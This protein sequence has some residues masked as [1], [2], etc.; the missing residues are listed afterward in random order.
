LGYVNYVLNVVTPESFNFDFESL[1]VVNFIILVSIIPIIIVVFRNKI[2]TLI[3]SVI[4]GLVFIALFG[5]NYI[6]WLGVGIIIILFLNA[7]KVGV[8]EIDQRIKI[9]PRTMIRRS[10]ISIIMAFF[11][12]IS[13]AAFQSPV[14]K[15]IAQN[16]QLPLASQQLFKSIVKSFINNQISSDLEKESIINQVTIQIFQQINNVLK[17]Y[18]RYAPPLL[19]FGLFIILWGLS[20]IFVW[21]AVL[22]G[23]MVFYVFRK[24]GFIKIEEYDIKAERIVI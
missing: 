14:A 6:N 9:N 20:W 12:L 13:F 5:S 2:W 4:V 24:I 23:V 3:L 21:V 1:A 22:F 18:F 11:I 10:A 8:E 7:R 16:Q 17:P 19:A 15:G